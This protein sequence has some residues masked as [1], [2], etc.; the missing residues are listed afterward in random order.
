MRYIDLM[1]GQKPHLL[2]DPEQLGRGDPRSLRI[3][4][5]LLSAGP[6]RRQALDHPLPFPVMWSS[7][8]RPRPFSRNRFVTRYAYHHGYY[9][10]VDASSA[11]SAWWSNWTPKKSPRSA[12]ERAFPTGDNLKPL[13]CAPGSDPYLVP[14]R[15]LPGSAR[16]TFSSRR[17]IIASRD[18]T[19]A[20]AD[21]LLLPDTVLPTDLTVEEER[22]ACRARQGLSPASGG[23]CAG[24]LD[25]ESHPYSVAES[26]YG[27]QTDTAQG[28]QSTRRLSGAFARGAAVPLRTQSSR[29][30][31]LSHSLTLKVDDF[32][33]V[34][35]SA[36]VGYGRRQ[37]DPDLEARDQLEQTQI[38]ITFTENTVTNRIDQPDAY[39]T[40]LGCETMTY[41]LTGLSLPLW[42]S[43]F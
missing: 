2:V 11:A 32:G 25:Q 21:A 1:G 5:P 40:P 42:A 26:N 30:P 31:L 28:E 7:A 43:P 22:E 29:S 24:W 27:L 10:G 9:D 37:P 12:P 34:L 41:E 4:H 23:L 16:I 20:D 15:R 18:T 3:F 8:S 36:A 38:L 33:N 13:P 6:T 35:R 19:T 17:S 14:H 39:R